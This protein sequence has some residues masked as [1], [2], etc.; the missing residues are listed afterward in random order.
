MPR[1]CLP[2]MPS[3]PPGARLRRAAL[4]LKKPLLV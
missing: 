3:S 4:K 2:L 1:A